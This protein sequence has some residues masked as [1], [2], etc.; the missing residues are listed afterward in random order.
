MAV[1]PGCGRPGRIT[2]DRVVKWPAT[3][4]GWSL[5]T[6]VIGPVIPFP[7]L[8]PLSFPLP[9][10]RK[11]GFKHIRGEHPS[12][13]RL[14][15]VSFG[16]LQGL[17]TS[18]AA[19]KARLTALARK[20]ALLTGPA[21][22][23]ESLINVVTELPAPPRVRAAAFR[24]LATL[25]IV[26]KVVTVDGHPG[27]RMSTTRFSWLRS[28]TLVVDPATSQ[29]QTVVNA[30]GGSMSITAGWVNRIP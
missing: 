13:G 3:Q 15:L 8:L 19:L 30:E 2:P 25:P 7:P 28:A 23:F 24:A 12:S 11:D 29:V 17:P 10:L 21:A 9:D 5:L 14:N 22:V 16:Q 27:L 26:I 1:R 20:P 18:P 6:G 4:A